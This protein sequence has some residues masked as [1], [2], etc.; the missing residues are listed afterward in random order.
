MLPLTDKIFSVNDSTFESTALQ[1]FKHQVE[2]VD[3][4][5]QFCK[6]L[7]RDPARV[8][9]IQDIPFLPIEFFKSYQVI[10]SGKSAAAVFESSGTTGVIPSRHYVADTSVYE[11]SFEIGFNQFYG[12]PSDYA[13]LALLP[14]YLERGN[15]S[16]VYMADKLIRISGN[17]TSGFF[18]NE[19][20]KLKEL[21]QQLKS[22]KQKTILL[23]V[24]FALLD[25]AEFCR[26]DFPELVIMETGGMKGRR[27][28]MTRLEI[29]EKLCA[30][31][32]VS[33]IHSEYGM[34]ELLSQ[35]YS[36]G[37]G[38]FNTPPWMKIFARD[39]YDPLKFGTEGAGGVNVIDLANIYSC[40]FIATAD[41]ARVN[42][43]TFEILGRMDNAEVRGCNLMVV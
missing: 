26:I 4:Y 20:D 30:A 24:T 37:E 35:A 12:P 9:S 36:K 27:E 28:E 2:T 14:S 18:L 16:L 40:S 17:N 13:I 7:K 38:I 11:R 10:Q 22:K 21:L 8:Q 25:F 15:S 19:F 42:N 1:I 5:Q 33:K 3:V 43:G 34:T 32:G 31:F 6:S 39:I 41:I 23:G 29:H